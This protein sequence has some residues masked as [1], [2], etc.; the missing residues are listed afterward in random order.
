M[1]NWV[2]NIVEITSPEDIFKDIVEFVNGENPFDFNKI[3]P[4]P[5]T[6]FKGDVGEKEKA[7]H[8]GNNWYDWSIKNWGTKWNSSDVTVNEINQI[9]TFS[10]AWS[11]PVPIIE[12]FARILPNISFVWT[13]A[14]EDR[15]NNTGKVRVDDGEMTGGVDTDGS[16]EALANYAYCWGED[17]YREEEEGGDET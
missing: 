10:T 4:M 5:D 6:V 17:E 1:P 16:A 15:G 7:E 11:V 14:D 8:G 9:L 3:I 12:A 13:W 2:M